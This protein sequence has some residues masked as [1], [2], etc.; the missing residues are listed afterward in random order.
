LPGRPAD[1]GESTCSTG[2]HARP[3]IVLTMAQKSRSRL[4]GGAG[5]GLAI[6]RG[7]VEA[8]GGRMWAQS[9]SGTGTV[10]HFTVPAAMPA[11]TRPG[12]NILFAPGPASA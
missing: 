9:E 11:G 12:V 2:R 8:H 1:S 4:H 7:L 5:L 6:A 3:V 10:V